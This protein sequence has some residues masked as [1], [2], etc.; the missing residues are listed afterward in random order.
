MTIKRKIIILCAAVAIIVAGIFYIFYDKPFEGSH[1]TYECDVKNFRLATTI[2]I[3]KDDKKFGEVRGNLVN[4]VTDPLTLYDKEETKVGYAGDAYHF[5]AQDSHAIYVNDEFSVEMVGLVDYFGE[6]YKIYDY[7][8]KLVAE[9]T[10]NTL[11]TS[12][13]MYDV[14]G[15]LIADYQSKAYANDFTV[16]ISENCTLDENT[17]LLIFCSY[18]SDQSYDNS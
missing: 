4:F 10:F 8:E 17:V 5:I 3:Y 2:Q 1:T 16:R 14:D 15:N 18:Y 9:V 7:D 13:E 11:N 12:G 6:S